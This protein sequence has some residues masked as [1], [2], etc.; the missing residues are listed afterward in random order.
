V[1]VATT[2]AVALI[3]EQDEL[4]GKRKSKAGGKFAGD[5]ITIAD[6][7]IGEERERQGYRILPIDEP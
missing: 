7:T 1:Q 2:P 4:G 6:R 3:G 5:S